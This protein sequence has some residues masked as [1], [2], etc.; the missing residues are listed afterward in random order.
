MTSVAIAR[1]G[2]ENCNDG[3]FTIADADVRSDRVADL[4]A[5]CCR[6]RRVRCPPVERGAIRSRQGPAVQ[7]RLQGLH[8]LVASG[9]GDIPSLAACEDVPSVATSAGDCRASWQT[10]AHG[11]PSRTRDATAGSEFVCAMAHAERCAAAINGNATS[12]G[13]AAS[14]GRATGRADGEIAGRGDSAS[15][16][17]AIPTGRRSFSCGCRVHDGKTRGCRHRQE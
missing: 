15:R 7:C 6:A 1:S 13:D 17:R 4:R 14:R 10:A 5:V 11:G 3:P 16:G 8:E 2:C 12:L 9:H